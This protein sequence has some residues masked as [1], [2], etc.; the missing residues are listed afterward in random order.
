MKKA[1]L[2]PRARLDFLSTFVHIG[3]HDSAAANR[4][5]DEFRKALQ[6]LSSFPGM[7]R[8]RDTLVP[9]MRSWPIKGFENYLIFY[10]AVEKGIEVLR[11]IH[12]ARDIDAI[13]SEAEE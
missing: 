3:K 12:G 7:G 10:R 5:R 9:G 11:V 2:K 8:M 13:F 6:L 4:F 1:F